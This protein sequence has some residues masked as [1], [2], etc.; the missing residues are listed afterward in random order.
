[1]STPAHDHT[2]IHADLGRLRSERAEV[3]RILSNIPAEQVIDRGSMEYR[4]EVLQEN[5]AVLERQLKH[6]R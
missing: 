6:T 3:V 4:L 5:I 1:M 2:T